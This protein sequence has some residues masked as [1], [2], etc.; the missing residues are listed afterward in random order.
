MSWPCKGYNSWNKLIP[1]PVGEGKW[2]RGES[3]QC[4]Y[5]WL[6]ESV[7]GSNRTGNEQNFI[8]WFMVIVLAYKLAV[9]LTCDKETADVLSILSLAWF[10]QIWLWTIQIILPFSR[11]NCPS[12][13]PLTL[14]YLAPRAWQAKDGRGLELTELPHQLLL[15]LRTC[16]APCR[17]W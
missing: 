5:W 8:N 6:W 4:G 16:S 9:T 13:Q 10:S 17:V 11:A 15:N 2:V 1:I 12:I 14:S 7:P 3:G